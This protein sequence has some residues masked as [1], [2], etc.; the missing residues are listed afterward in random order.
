MVV[1]RARQ[2]LTRLPSREARRH[3]ATAAILGTVLSVDHADRATIGAVAPALEH[4]LH[5]G[6][7][8]IGLLAGAFSIAVAIGTLPVGVLTDR[9]RRVTL[10]AA[11]LVCWSVAM[12]ATGWSTSFAMFF[13]TQAALGVLAA[14]GLPVVLSLAGDYFPRRKRSRFLAV[15]NSGELVG[16][17]LGFVL[18]GMIATRLSWRW[19]FWVLGIAGIGV[20]ALVRRLHEPERGRMEDSDETEKREDSDVS[21]RAALSYVI[22]VRTNVY[23]MLAGAL[24][25]AFFAVLRTFAVLYVLRT[26]GVRPQQSTPLVPIVGVAALTGMFGGGRLA[27]RLMERGSKAG[28]VWVAVIGYVVAALALLGAI[29]TRSLLIAAPLCLIGAAGLA[30]PNP[31]LDAIRLD[32]ILPRLRGRAE[33]VRTIVRTVGEA[34]GPPVF[35]VLSEH[36]AGG[37]RKGLQASAAALLPALLVAAVFLALAARSYPADAEAVRREVMPQRGTR[38]I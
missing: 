24:G 33:S 37:G 11:G 9:F 29:A 23:V 26:F 25:I 12:I 3:I 38:R 5:I 7:T 16:A 15:V 18:A 17:G 21:L 20:L 4:A 36:L 8:Q 28:R 2:R 14:I 31:A 22:R 32:V 27:D 13:T 10:L 19:S 6:N 35:G 34:V 30:A 1:A